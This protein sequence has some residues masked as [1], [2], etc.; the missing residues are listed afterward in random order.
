MVP[1]WRTTSLLNKTVV[2]LCVINQLWQLC[3]AQGYNMAKQSYDKLQSK[4][5]YIYCSNCVCVYCIV[6]VSCSICVCISQY[7]S[8]S[9][10]ELAD[11]S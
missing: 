1:R 4:Y 7:L 11:H 8:S 9:V 2:T 5:A 6:C 3:T 10:L